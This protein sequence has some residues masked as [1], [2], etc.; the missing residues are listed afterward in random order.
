[1]ATTKNKAAASSKTSGPKT[2]DEKIG[3]IEKETKKSASALKTKAD[4][5]VDDIK[6]AVE[7][8]KEKADKKTTS[9]KPAAKK[10][11]EIFV[12][13]GELEI[14]TDDIIEKAKN[15]FVAAGNKKT[16]AKDIKIY[17]KPE[18]NMVYFVINGDYNGSFSI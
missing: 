6:D 10:N 16:D 1:M 8:I 18:E 15:V 5:K 12:Q 17:I 3:K 2:A 9:R 7:E 14:K 13:Y 11:T 4:K